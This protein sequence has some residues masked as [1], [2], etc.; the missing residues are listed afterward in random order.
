MVSQGVFVPTTRLVVLS[1]AIR[2][3]VGLGCAVLLR[4]LPLF[5]QINTG[6]ILGTVTDQTGGVIAGA[7]VTVTNTETG[8]ARNL[9]ADGAGEYDAPNLNPG[10]YSVRVSTAGFEAFE[11]QNIALG[12]G[13]GA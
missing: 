4:G 12:V 8:V 3:V 10:K 11:R 2:A 6:R 9:V 5:S 7:M 13:Q 1:R